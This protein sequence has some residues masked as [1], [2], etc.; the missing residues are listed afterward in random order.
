MLDLDYHCTLSET[1]KATWNA[2]KSVCTNFL[3][4][5]KAEKYRETVS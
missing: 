3:G 2:S 4:D 5:H 1:E